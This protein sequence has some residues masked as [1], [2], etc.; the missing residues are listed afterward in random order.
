[1]KETLNTLEYLFDLEETNYGTHGLL[2]EFCDEK[3]VNI[4]EELTKC[5]EEELQ[6]KTAAMMKCITKNTED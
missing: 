4:V 2:E 1:M 5:E 3:G 6:A